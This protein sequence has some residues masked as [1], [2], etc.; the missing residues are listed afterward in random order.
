MSWRS[1]MSM[2]IQTAEAALYR[3]TNVYRG[4]SERTTLGNSFSVVAAGAC[5]D[6]CDV[7]A[8]IAGAAC[9]EL[10]FPA[11]LICAAAA[12]VGDLVCKSECGSGG[13]SGG[14]GGS[15]GCCP[16]GR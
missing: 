15:R 4:Y 10:P 3:S 6:A 1:I 8:A 11:D 5:E 14:G 2:P 13:G 9:G 12:A 7:G 16:P